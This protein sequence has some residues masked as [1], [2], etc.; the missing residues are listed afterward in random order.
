MP[1]YNLIQPLFAD[2][3]SIIHAIA[4]IP[5]N[6]CAATTAIRDYHIQSWPFFF[7]VKATHRLIKDIRISVFSR[8]IYPYT[9]KVSYLTPWLALRFKAPK[10]SLLVC[11]TVILKI[12][13]LINRANVSIRGRKGNYR[14][15]VIILYCSYPPPTKMTLHLIRS[16]LAAYTAA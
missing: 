16:N 8:L 14:T 4:I 11:Q 10:I 6:P 5:Y 2:R 3:A 13:D 12:T 15:N 1:V 7:C 9:L